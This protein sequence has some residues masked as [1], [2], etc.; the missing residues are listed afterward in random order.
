MDKNKAKQIERNQLVMDHLYLVKYCALRL[1][2]R[3]PQ[4]SIDFN[5]LYSAGV[6]GLIDAAEKFNPELGIP[7]EKY[8]SIRIKGAM[9]DEIR[10]NDP[11]PRTV[12]AM[13]SRL[14]RAIDRLE[15]KLGRMP[16][17]G[18]I[19]KEIGVSN[20][21]FRQMLD[22]V[23]SV[24]L[25]SQSLDE[26]LEGGVYPDELIESGEEPLRSL[27]Q[28]ELSAILSEL[29]SQL[30]EREQLILSLYYY[31][32]LTMKEIGQILGYTESRVSQLHTQILLKLRTRLK[33]RLYKANV[34]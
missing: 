7:F 12:R 6:M 16:E 29:I 19:A 25:F 5:D 20:D 8:A 11:V 23:R 24:S 31:E 1:L 2:S 14:E 30:P 4:D 26:M 10:L 9:L 34:P 18:E 17:E 21:E 13:I 33:R 22:E 15:K 28:E 3:V 32:E 27:Q